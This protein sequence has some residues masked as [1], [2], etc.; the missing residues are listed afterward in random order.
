MHYHFNQSL[1]K[2]ERAN[3]VVESNVGGGRC[4]Q[5]FL[6]RRDWRV[7][8]ARLAAFCALRGDVSN[9]SRLSHDARARHAGRR[10]AGRPVRP[11]VADVLGGQ[12]VR[13]R[14]GAVFGQSLCIERDRDDVAR[15]D[16]AARR[17]RVFGRLGAA[18][19]IEHPSGQEGIAAAI[20]RMKQLRGWANL[21]PPYAVRTPPEPAHAKGPQPCKCLEASIHFCR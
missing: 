16:Y 13:G 9:R 7:R 4:R 20:H 15:G 1:T 2:S 18:G 11:S 3:F 14:D 21:V 5:R 8:R 17:P 19:D 10:A 12:A 6:V